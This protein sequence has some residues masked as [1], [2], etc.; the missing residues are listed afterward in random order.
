MQHKHFCSFAALDSLV[1][2]KTLFRKLLKQNNNSE[3]RKTY[4]NDIKLSIMYG[5]TSVSK[6]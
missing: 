3:H 2:H 5:R 6:Q 4:K 1:G